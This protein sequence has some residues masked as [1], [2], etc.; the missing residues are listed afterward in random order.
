VAVEEIARLRARRRRIVTLR[1][2]GALPPLGSVR[3]VAD[4]Q[5]R[6]GRV[7]CT[8]DGDIG[9]FL[10]ALASVRV[11]DLTVEVPRLEEAFLDFYG[12][13]APR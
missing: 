11:V 5:M 10:A 1:V 12:G 6:D 13:A 3:G 8:V 4:L 9:P 2:E 7:T